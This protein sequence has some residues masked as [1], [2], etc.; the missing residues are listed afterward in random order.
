MADYLTGALESQA[1]GTWRP[2][3]LPGMEEYAEVALAIGEDH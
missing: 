3:Y 2:S 1:V